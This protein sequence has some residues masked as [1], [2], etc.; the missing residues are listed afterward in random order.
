MH[1]RRYFYKYTTAETALAIL[2]NR[3]LKY[4]SPVLFNDPFDV[5][6]T[7]D[8]GFTTDEY[9]SAYTE[10][11]IRFMQ[12]DKEPVCVNP[13]SDFMSLM[14][15]RKLYK[16]KS[17]PVQLFREVES[18]MLEKQRA[19]IESYAESVNQW[20][21][22]LVK[23]ARVFCVAEE[24]DNLLMW[25]HYAENHKGVVL[26]FECNEEWDFSLCAATGV[27]YV[28]TPPTLG[29]LK[30]FI[31]GQT[32]QGPPL[33]NDTYFKEIINAKSSH[34]SYEKE[35]RVF[36]PPDDL[37]SPCVKRDNDGNEVLHDFIELH[38]QELSSVFYGCRIDPKDK[39]QI[40][41][42][43]VGDFQHVKRYNA[44]RNERHYKLDCIL[45]D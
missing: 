15:L 10:E 3:T 4:S 24:H 9:L 34:W 11:M 36:I 26:E 45:C 8:F 31:D 27:K 12:S 25:A 30:E 41:D 28:R 37:K 19:L 42:Y 23:A 43:L 22:N 14:L 38:P 18:P 5:Q 39:K 16:E 21:Q 6:T 20:F 40:G 2:R 44:V 29:G 13:T 35:W 7:I 1:D 33:N 17:L 32:G